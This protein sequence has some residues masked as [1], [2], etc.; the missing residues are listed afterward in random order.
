MTMNDLFPPILVQHVLVTDVA[1]AVNSPA[2]ARARTLLPDLS[3]DD[4]IALAH[5]CIARAWPE[6]E[7]TGYGRV[8]AALACTYQVAKELEPDHE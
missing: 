6:S 1:R 7:T 5:V 8:Q 3:S 2:L 4:L